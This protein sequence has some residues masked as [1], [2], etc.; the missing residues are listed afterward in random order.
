[1]VSRERKQQFFV[2]LKEL[3][4][5]YK[6]IMFVGADNV[7]STQMHEV[8][9]ALRG[10]GVILMG[11]NTMVRRCIR[12]AL[13][14]NPEY[15]RLLALCKGNV[16]LVFT[17][18][19]L[20]EVRDIIKANRKG[21]PAKAGT[22]SPVDVVVPAGPTGLEPTQTSFL[23]A[24]DIPSKIVKGRIEIT[25]PVDLIA[26]GQKVTASQSALLQKLGIFPFSFGLEPVM[27]FD[28]GS[29]YSPRVLDMTDADIIERFNEAITQ[30][31]CISL[32]V[33]YPTYP[34]VKHSVLNGYKNVLALSVATDYTFKQSEKIKEMLANPE[35]FAVAAPVAAVVEEKV[36]EKVEEPEESDD[37]M[38]MGLFD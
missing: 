34:S 10:K 4:D 35:A 27:I 32:A 15:E 17:D 38:G 16:G 22:I 26:I 23:Q 1:M 31:S 28:E 5:K 29:V 33:H 37:D 9:R 24:L 19:E 7:K 20:T 13:E 18:V 14:A 21:A 3:L 25:A 6:R 36:E 30:I 11:K 12:D 8:R 2:Q